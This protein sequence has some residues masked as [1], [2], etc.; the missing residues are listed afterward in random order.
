M[1]RPNVPSVAPPPKGERRYKL[2]MSYDGT[3]FH[4]FAKNPGVETVEGLLIQALQKVLGKAPTLTCAG[5]T[6]AGVHAKAQVVSFDLVPFE[7]EKVQKALNALC[8]PFVVITSIEETA[9]DFNARFSAI[10]RTY[11]YQILNQAHPDPFLSRYTWH[12]YTPISI[13]KMNTAGQQ[14]LGEHDFSSFCRKHVL[15]IEGQKVSASL[16]REIKTLRWE[17][18]DDNLIE[19]WITA[20]A[21]CHQM[22]RSITGTLVDIGVG[23]IDGFSI[24]EILSAR[25]RNIAGQV[26]PPHGLALWNVNY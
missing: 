6:D 19:L 10:S 9:D 17:V 8:Y 4:G 22:V 11:R 16:I 24:L 15:E 26:A 5:R 1:I 14:L 13:E 20:N 12:V 2:T 23:K 7:I 3:T 25:D 18:S 21:F